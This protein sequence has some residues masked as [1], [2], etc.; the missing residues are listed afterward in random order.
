MKLIFSLLLSLAICGTALAE[1]DLS[2][3][4]DFRKT[5]AEYQEL[6]KKFG[7]KGKYDIASL[8]QRMAEIKMDAAA[9]ADMGDWDSI[10]WTEYEQIENKIA[11]LMEKKK[12]Y[13]KY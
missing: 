11:S 6:A 12:K 8:Y 9:K 7:D 3:G 5:A 4:D 10:D 13:K 2:A 1:D